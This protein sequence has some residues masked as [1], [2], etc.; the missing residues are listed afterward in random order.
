MEGT[1]PSTINA[2]GIRPIFVLTPNNMKVAK[3]EFNR[4]VYRFK[5]YNSMLG[6]E[7][8]EERTTRQHSVSIIP[9]ITV[10]LRKATDG[11]YHKYLLESIVWEL[12][13][14]TL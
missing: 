12:G 9:R 7:W 14:I 6:W 5:F 3:S 11:S 13:L 2:N 1:D 10:A 4:D 8:S